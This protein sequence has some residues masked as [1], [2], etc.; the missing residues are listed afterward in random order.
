MHQ[1]SQML[2]RIDFHVTLVNGL[3]TDYNYRYR[4]ST[5][6]SYSTDESDMR[7]DSGQ[8]LTLLT[9]GDNGR[10]SLICCFVKKKEAKR[11]FINAINS[12]S[13]ADITK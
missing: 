13:E 7:I 2:S 9:H 11:F 4:Y 3:S 6:D 12:I 5:D 10:V 8:R 1:Q